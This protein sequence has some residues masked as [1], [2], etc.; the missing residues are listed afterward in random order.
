MLRILLFM[1]GSMSIGFVLWNILYWKAN[2]CLV[3]I[4]IGILSVYDLF[5]ILAVVG[6][7][8]SFL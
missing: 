2:H 1:T 6:F 4:Q 8:L 3:K 5:V 7:I